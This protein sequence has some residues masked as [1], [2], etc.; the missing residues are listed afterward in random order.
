M[1]EPEVSVKVTPA[2]NKEAGNAILSKYQAR[3]VWAGPNSGTP[4]WTFHSVAGLTEQNVDSFIQEFKV[5]PG[6]ESIYKKPPASL[7]G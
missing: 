4:A 6:V 7:P 5:L 2:F 1:S 3:F